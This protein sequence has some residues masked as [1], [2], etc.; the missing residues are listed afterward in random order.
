MQHVVDHRGDFVREEHAQLFADHFDTQRVDRPNDRFVLTVE[1]LQPRMDIV[2]ELP[3]DHPV[4]RD[5]EHIV[6]VG[7]PSCRVQDSLD[8][9]HKAERLATSRTGDAT[10]GG[11]VRIDENGHLCA[12]DTFVPGVQH[13]DECNAADPLAATSDVGRIL[14]WAASSIFSDRTDRR[15]GCPAGVSGVPQ[16]RFLGEVWVNERG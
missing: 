8:P 13:R 5:Y 2:P 15:T 7:A 14:V 16:D 9:A 3:S 1:R 10:E 4:E 12:T 6:A 11:R